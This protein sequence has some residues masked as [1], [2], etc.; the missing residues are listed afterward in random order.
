MRIMIGKEKAVPVT[1]KLPPE[2]HLAKLDW[3][4]RQE[5]KARPGRYISRGDVVRRLILEAGK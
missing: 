2:P 1:V 3:L 4:L 5:R